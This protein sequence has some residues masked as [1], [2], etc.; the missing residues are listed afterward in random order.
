MAHRSRALIPMRDF[1]TRM[2][3]VRQQPR[4][5]HQRAD[6]CLPSTSDILS[7]SCR[8]SKVP[9]TDMVLLNSVLSI[10]AMREAG[11]QVIYGLVIILM[12]LVFGP[13]LTRDKLERFISLSFSSRA[14]FSFWTSSTCYVVSAHPPDCGT[15]WQGST[16]F[17]KYHRPTQQ[18]PSAPLSQLASER[19]SI[20]WPSIF[21]I[22]RSE[23]KPGVKADYWQCIH[24]PDYLWRL[25]YN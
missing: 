11:R 25:Y 16:D 12:L 14:Q 23:P 4:F 15:R 20:L 24:F 22:L 21:R 7:V 2:S 19:I 6:S 5:E 1:S 17:A 3:E 18:A 8:V 13:R 10:M 9:I